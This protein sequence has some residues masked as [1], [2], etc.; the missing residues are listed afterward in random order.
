MQLNL[1][2]TNSRPVSYH[3]ANKNK[4]VKQKHKKFDNESIIMWVAI[5]TIIVLLGVGFFVSNNR[6][7]LNSYESPQGE[8]VYDW[9]SYYG[10][11][12]AG[13]LQAE[14]EEEGYEVMSIFVSNV[15]TSPGTALYFGDGDKIDCEGSDNDCISSKRNIRVKMKSLG[16][17][18]DQI[19]RVVFDSLLMENIYG[20]WI[21][22]LSPT[23]TC[24]YVIK[25]DDWVSCLNDKTYTCNPD[26]F[27]FEDS[28]LLCE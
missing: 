18:A 15:A 7:I 16:N 14:L 9:E 4:M 2:I 17:R 22:I 10:D 23:D 24:V 20:Y 19:K 3:V 11:D 13:Y 6:K 21:E 28:L 12:W 27:V 26:K 1:V 8:R 5:I 25:L